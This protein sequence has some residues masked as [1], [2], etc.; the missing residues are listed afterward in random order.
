MN[1]DK[2]RYTDRDVVCA[3]VAYYAQDN[4]LDADDEGYEQWQE[5][6]RRGQ[7]IL[8]DA[9]LLATA[10]C[11][12]FTAYSEQMRNSLIEAAAESRVAPIVQVGAG[13]I[14]A[15]EAIRWATLVEK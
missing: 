2:L 5:D 14:A 15:Q 10:R 3:F 6:L 7:D 4:Y 1:E 8:R 9:R 11:A 12:R 13:H